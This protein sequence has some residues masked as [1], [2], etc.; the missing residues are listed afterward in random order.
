MILASPVAICCMPSATARRPE[1]QSW[2]TP[3][4]VASFGMPA[5]IAAWRAGFW[6]SPAGQHLAEDHLIHFA[7][8]DAGARERALNDRRAEFMG[9]DR[10]ESAVERTDC[11]ST[12][13]GDDDG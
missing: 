11:C 6:P 8:L 4:A 5:L 10:C 7:G 13:A 2:L 3:Q 12:C 1:P 9:G